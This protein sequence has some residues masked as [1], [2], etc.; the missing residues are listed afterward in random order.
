MVVV[1]VIAVDVTSASV[2]VSVSAGRQR[3]LQLTVVGC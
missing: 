2:L 1:D 3:A